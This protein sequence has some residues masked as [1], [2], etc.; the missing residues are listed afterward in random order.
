[1]KWHFLFSRLNCMQWW[2]RVNMW[3][4]CSCALVR[5]R[6]C[7][8]GYFSSNL[9]WSTSHNIS[10][11]GKGQDFIA[12]SMKHF[13][14]VRQFLLFKMLFHFFLSQLFKRLIHTTINYK[15]IRIFHSI[16]FSVDHSLTVQPFSIREKTKYSKRKA[17]MQTHTQVYHCGN[18]VFFSSFG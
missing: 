4:Q 8:C 10:F 11:Y 13:E 14:Y 1:M 3:K 17:Y 9:Q 15:A 5:P 6:E 2:F 7:V 18:R 12:V 16:S